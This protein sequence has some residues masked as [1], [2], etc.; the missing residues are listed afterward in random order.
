M[1]K[2]II[3]DDELHVRKHI[4]EICKQSF[5]NEIQI[6]ASCGTIDEGVKNITQLKPDFIFLDI[7]IQNKSGFEVVER[8]KNVVN[9]EIVFVTAHAEYA[10]RA[11][12]S[13]AMHYILKPITENH[14][15][16]VVARLKKRK[17]QT[18]KVDRISILMDNMSTNSTYSPRI[19]IPN[20][21]GFE[22]FSVNTITHLKADGSYCEIFTINDEKGFVCSKSLKSVQDQLDPA[23]FKK[24]HRSYLVNINYVKSFDKSLGNIYLVDGTVLPMSIRNKKD[25]SNAFFTP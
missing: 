13:A 6:V 8:T 9:C 20:A 14:I 16:E 21:H 12:E 3:I 17:T 2:A 4:E 18:T 19:V 10:I 24:C 25:F 15:K 5:P 22:V 23:I 11:F 7:S 1:I